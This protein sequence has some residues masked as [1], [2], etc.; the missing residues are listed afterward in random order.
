MDNSF[1]LAS[2]S[3]DEILA[4]IDAFTAERLMQAYESSNKTAFVAALIG[5][6][7]LNELRGK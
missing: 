6:I 7:V 2:K 5:R 1:T 4:Q 3:I